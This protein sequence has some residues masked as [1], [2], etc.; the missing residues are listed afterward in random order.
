MCESLEVLLVSVSPCFLKQDTQSGCVYRKPMQSYNAIILTFFSA[1]FPLKKTSMFKVGRLHVSCDMCTHSL[2]TQS[3]T[4]LILG[5]TARYELTNLNL[6]C[7]W[8]KLNMSIGAEELS[9]YPFL[10][11]LK[12]TNKETYQ[13]RERL[14]RFLKYQF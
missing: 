7:W 8:H 12:D 9:I 5:E 2:I 11:H 13:L 1:V 6:Y 4:L 10:Y 3:Q 14:K